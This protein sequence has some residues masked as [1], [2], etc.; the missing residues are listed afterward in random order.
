MDI[1]QPRQIR[2]RGEPVEQR[3]AERLLEE[4]H[5]TVAD[6]N[7]P[8]AVV[9]LPGGGNGGGYVP[10]AEAAEEVEGEQQPGRIGR[11]LI[12]LIFLIIGIV[13]SSPA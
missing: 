8:E 1:P 12:P 10:E 3:E 9:T 6:E 11:F 13:K 4:L 5:E 2:E 7:E